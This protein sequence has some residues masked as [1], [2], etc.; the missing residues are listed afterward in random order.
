MSLLKSAGN[1]YFAYQFLTK[2][3]T[4]FDKTD[5]FRLGIID[6]KGKVLKKRS[7]LKSQEEKEAYTI[8][9]TMIFNLK[10]LLGKVPGGRTRFATFAAA[11]FLLKEDLTYRHYQ[12]Q[13][14]LQEE[15]FKFMKTDEKDVQMVREQIT[16]R[17]KYLDELDA[18]S[19]NIASIGVGPDGEPPGI[20]AAQ[21][22]K[23]REKFAGAEVFTVDPN[24]FMKAR[25]G[26]KKYAKYE[27]YVGNDEVGEEIR[28]YGRANPSKPIIIKDSL[29]GAM[30]YLKYGKDNA[31]VQNFY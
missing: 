14:F 7:K 22:K 17:E 24:V 30:L 27:N 6:E 19:G 26:K 29:T 31:R 3:T 4:P 1:I 15:F 8:T 20:T 18:G 5:A 16:L 11:L 12:D 25:F 10:K 21:K 9:D 13:S 2:L 28:Q 23:K